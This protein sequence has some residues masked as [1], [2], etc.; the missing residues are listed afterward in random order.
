MAGEDP[1]YTAKVRRLPCAMAL[2]D[3]CGGEVAA[4]HEIDA[5]RLGM[6]MRAHDRR[7]M[8]LCAK[9]HDAFHRG[10]KPF[11][12]WTREERAAWQNHK[13]MKASDY[14][15]GLDQITWF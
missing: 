7:T 12:G 1:E 4:H 2:D 11:D 15:T 14:V 5:G 3:P 9:H 10:T 13:I 6:S 8:P